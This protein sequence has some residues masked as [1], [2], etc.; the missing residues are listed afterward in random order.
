MHN[1]QH[2]QFRSPSPEFGEGRKLSGA[3]KAELW[4]LLENDPH[5]PSRVLL[6]EI[7]QTRGPIG[8]SERH[9]NRVRQKWNRS[10]PKGRPR[11]SEAGASPDPRASRVQVTPH[12]SHIGVHLFDAWME[13][14]NGFGPVVERL[15]FGIRSYLERH[16]DEAFALLQHR[17]ETLKARFKALFYAPL[18]DMGK[19]S[20][21]D[22]QE[23]PLET[24]LGRTYQSSTLNQFLGQL[25]RIDAATWLM[26]VLVAAQSGK[27]G[28]IDGH[29]IAFWTSGSMHKGFPVVMEKF[30]RLRNGAARLPQRS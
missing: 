4:T 1:A 18:F 13:Q 22:Y 10:S 20:Q 21:F 25:E 2:N 5:K 30:W 16:P 6:Q 12:L 19:L 27:I 9:L 29:M 7:A 8:V 15:Q 26:P 3:Q 28:Y 23:H 24:L 11:K 17:E 14:Q